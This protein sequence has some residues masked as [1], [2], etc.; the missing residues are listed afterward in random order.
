[1]KDKYGDDPRFVK[2][3]AAL[4]VD[5]DNPPSKEKKKVCPKCGAKELVVRERHPD[6]DINY[7]ERRCLAC[8][9]RKEV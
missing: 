3:M 7:M 6:T 2:L 5:P 8:G 9:Y 1:L 4:G